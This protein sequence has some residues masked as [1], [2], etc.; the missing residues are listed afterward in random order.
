[1]ARQC[2]ERGCRTIK[3]G[4]KIEHCTSC[5]MS[6]TSTKSGDMHRVGSYEDGSRRCRT[7]QE[8][9]EL[10]MNLNQHGYWSCGGRGRSETAPSRHPA[11]VSEGRTVVGTASG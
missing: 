8:L 4:T 1:M 2:T 3:P 6:F 7:N 10:G 9:V 11:T 5:H